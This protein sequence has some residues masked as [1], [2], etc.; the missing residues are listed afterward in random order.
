M[1][2]EVTV[3]G[4]VNLDLIA[5]VARLPQPGETITGGSFLSA[6]GGK[7]A[8]QA[9]AAARAGAETALIGAVGEDDFA[10][11]A[12]A[13]LRSEKVDLENLFTLPGPTGTAL[14][15]VG[16]SG[17]NMI[18]VASGANYALS[19]EGLATLAVP[20][21]GLVLSQLEMDL[22]VTAGFLE[23]AKDQ[24]ARVLLNLAP[25]RAEVAAFLAT[26]DLL[27]MNEG[28]A[29]ALGGI[30]GLNGLAAEPLCT[31]L[32]KVIARDI[33]MTLGA[34]GLVAQLAGDLLRV[35]AFEVSAVDTVGAGDAFC[36]Y[37]AQAIAERGRPDEWALRFAAAAGALTCTR[38]GAQTAIPTRLEVEALLNQNHQEPR[39]REA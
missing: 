6:P 18:A 11:Q 22:E 25:F 34:E 39:G 14:I 5:R 35:P 12:L 32:R 2:A 38:R 21:D 37:L 20:A 13:L 24:G 10:E 27:V 33:V 30:L 19:A 9:L 8:N 7:G 26:A 3:F 31:A 23:R 4:S 16:E 1:A 36:G 17:E 28:E 15:L 29:R